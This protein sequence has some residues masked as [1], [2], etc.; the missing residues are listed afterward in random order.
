[1]NISKKVIVGA[2]ASALIGGSAFALSERTQLHIK[3]GIQAGKDAAKTSI[4]LRAEGQSGTVAATNFVDDNQVTVGTVAIT[5]DDNG[6]LTT[7][8]DFTDTQTDNAIDKT[9]HLSTYEAGRVMDADDFNTS[10]T[11]AAGDEI[12]TAVAGVTNTSQFTINNLRAYMSNSYNC[13]PE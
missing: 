8:V 6:G 10:C 7:V 2:L 5:D 3:L 9:T 13:T 1:M 4:L 11:Y 12:E